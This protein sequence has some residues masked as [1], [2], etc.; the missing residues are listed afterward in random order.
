VSKDQEDVLKGRTLK[1]YWFMLKAGKPVRVTDI[2]QKLQF[3][4]PSLV[5]YHVNKLVEAGLVAEEQAGFIVKRVEIEHFFML[6][7]VVIPF[8]VAYACFFATTLA[9]MLVILAR[10]GSSSLTSFD[11]LAISVNAV[12]LGVAV[13][14][15]VRTLRTMP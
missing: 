3:S 1:V 2:Q 6:R 15:T 8:Q 4:S 12:A 9:A 7:G 5:Q 13:Y 14:E 11:F 10:A